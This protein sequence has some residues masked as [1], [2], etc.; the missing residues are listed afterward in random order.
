MARR[1]KRPG[2]PDEQRTFDEIYR[3]EAP[4]NGTDTSAEAAEQMDLS[5]LNRMRLEVLDAI[6]RQPQTDQQVQ[7]R[8]GMDPSTER[9]RRRE[10]VLAGLI[11][12]S[13][14]KDWTRAHRRA[15]VWESVE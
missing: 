6:R 8:L 10:L 12:A 15:M 1:R 4:H 9:P 7:D 5:T 14:R 3:G 2:K 11:R 13:G